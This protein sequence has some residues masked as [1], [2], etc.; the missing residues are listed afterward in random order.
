[1]CCY[2]CW[3]ATGAAVLV[4]ATSEEEA[5]A[6]AEQLAIDDGYPE[7]AVVRIEALS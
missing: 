4:D 6:K 3:L 2:R 7:H 5:H 1:M